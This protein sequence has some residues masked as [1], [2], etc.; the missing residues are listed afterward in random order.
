MHVTLDQARAFDA[1]ARA[2]TFVG[3]A[4]RLHKAH[5]AVLYALKQLET[6]TGLTLLD[7]RSYRSR[8]TGAGE[9]VLTHCRA[10]LSEERKLLEA[11]QTLQSGWEPALRVVFD[12][13]FPLSALLPVIR[14]LRESKASTRVHVTADSLAGVERRFDAE[15]AHVMI[16]VLPL[17]RPDLVGHRLPT[18]SATLVAAKEHPLAKKKGVLTSAE[19]AQHVLL[20]VQGSDP[21][22][23]LPTGDLDT[24][25]QVRLSDFYAK[26]AAILD[27]IGFGWLP[28]WLVEGPLAKGRVKALRIGRASSHRFEPRVYHHPSL[29]RAAQVLIT[30]LTQK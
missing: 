9:A 11:C 18:I 15:Q 21:R 19:L 7:R 5:T 16:S 30:S 27:G 25:S 22:L 14:Q 24:Q 6:Q 1:L 20:T 3:A 10:L 13:I 8:L 28:D 23:Q 4:K 12:A 26:Q 17:E 2:G 29:G